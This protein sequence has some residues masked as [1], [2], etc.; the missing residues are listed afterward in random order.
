MCDATA[1]HRYSTQ[2][3]AWAFALSSQCSD[4]LSSP[5]SL[6]AV[7]MCIVQVRWDA[8]FESLK[9]NGAV[10][11]RSVVSRTDVW[12]WHPPWNPLEQPHPQRLGHDPGH[13]GQ[14]RLAGRRACIPRAGFAAC[15][16]CNGSAL[17]H[18]CR[19]HTPNALRFDEVQRLGE[20]VAS[21]CR[22]ARAN[23]ESPDA[24]DLVWGR[25]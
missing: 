1:S 25:L 8:R 16:A 2:C 12:G 7:T 14:R 6:Y 21:D 15:K 24:E 4:S 10:P 20:K 3:T 11:S 18:H 22:R 9:D 19:H 13:E 5:H 17:E 23:V